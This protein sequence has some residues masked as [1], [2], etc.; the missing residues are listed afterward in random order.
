MREL[1]LCTLSTI[2]CQ[3]VIQ[4]QNQGKNFWLK[5]P[6][7]SEDDLHAIFLRQPTKWKLTSY[8]WLVAFGF[9]RLSSEGNVLT[10]HTA[11]RPFQLSRQKQI[12]DLYTKLRFC[13]NLAV[14]MCD[15][16]LSAECFCSLSHVARKCEG[17]GRTDNAGSRNHTGGEVTVSLAVS[18]EGGSLQ[19]VVGL[20]SRPSLHHRIT[21]I[22][23]PI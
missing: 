10:L 6:K 22:L 8:L 5:L 17:K 14:G 2:A 16:T 13:G 19:L 12:G 18:Q 9:L 4:L 11:S 15:L 1:L 20:V 3:S 23:S 7:L 21:L